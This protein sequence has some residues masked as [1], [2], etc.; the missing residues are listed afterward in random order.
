MGLR[1]W[2]STCSTATESVVAKMAPRAKMSCSFAQRGVSGRKFFKMNLV[3]NGL[4]C[5]AY[6]HRVSWEHQIR[7][8]KLGTSLYVLL[9]FKLLMQLAAAGASRVLRLKPSNMSDWHTLY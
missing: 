1:S 5:F 2:S 4:K 7:E 9:F 8:C 6:R 3:S